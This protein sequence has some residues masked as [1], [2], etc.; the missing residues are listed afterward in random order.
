M[1]LTHPRNRHHSAAG[2]WWSVVHLDASRH[3]ADEQRETSIDTRL[4]RNTKDTP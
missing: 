2:V 1:V 3:G 4:P